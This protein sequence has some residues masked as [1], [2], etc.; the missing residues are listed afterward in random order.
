MKNQLLFIFCF[1]C[2]SHLLAQPMLYE[3]FNYPIGT[4]AGNGGWLQQTPGVNYPTLVANSGL[5]Y[6]GYPVSGSIGNKSGVAYYGVGSD[7]IVFKSFSPISSGTIYASFLINYQTTSNL[8]Q[9]Y[10]IRLNAASPTI[11]ALK[12][13]GSISPSIFYPQLQLWNN[14]SSSINPP[15]LAG[16]QTHLIVLSYKFSS[17]AGEHDTAKMFINPVLSAIEPIPDLVYG[18]GTDFP[19]PIERFY[20]HDDANTLCY[21]DEIMVDTTWAGV[22]TS[23]TAALATANFAVTGNNNICQGASVIYNN[24]SQNAVSY[25]WSFPGGT[26]STSTAANPTITYNSPGVYSATLIAT[27]ATNQSTTFTL[28]NAVTVSIAPPI[29]EIVTCGATTFC[30]GNSINLLSSS[31]T[32]NVWSPNNQSTQSIS[33]NASGSYTVTVTDPNGCAATSLPTTVVVNANPAVPTISANGATT[34]CV[35]GSV[36]LSSSSVSNNVWTPSNQTSQNITVNAAGTYSVTVSNANACT[37]TSAPLIITVNANP[38]TPTVIASGATTFCAGNSVTLLSSSATGNLWTPNN[39]TTQTITANTTS[40]YSVMVTDANGC[41][42]TSASLMVTANPNP[43]SPTISANGATTFC[44]GGSVMLTSNSATGNV[45]TPTNATS[46][47]INADSTGSYQVTVTNNFGCSALS[48]SLQVTANPNPE[49]PIISQAGTFL[50]SSIGNGNQWQLNGQN[51]PSATNQLYS[52][53]QIG[54]YGVL[55]T[56]IFGCS[57]MS[58][59]TCLISVK[60]EERVAHYFSVY[61]NPSR[62]GEFLLSFSEEWVGKTVFIG[63]IDELGHQIQPLTSI[64]LTNKEL[65]IKVAQKGI[66]F[67]QIRQGKSIE[68]QKI[69]L[70]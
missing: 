8:V 27:N 69:I 3:G 4:L 12:F 33:V 17:G 10:F 61:P 49:T 62:N 47:S 16:F 31:A 64:W 34:F 67:V 22:I 58:D 30:A 59:T 1:A 39:A 21:V 54:C 66:Y 57:A 60:M 9:D 52:P 14:N 38:P 2:V 44:V 35:G 13:G 20:I 15:Q 46:Q 50:V 70:L 6:L 68:T 55:A 53:S 29:P 7:D 56:N 48:N 32:G 25:S 45:W 41:T 11:S 23:V 51:I 63:I 19:Y 24:L 43:P 40:L 36:M 26:P 18:V 37:A 28:A 5:S 42:A 65:P